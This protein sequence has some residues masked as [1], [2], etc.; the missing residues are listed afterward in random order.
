M[1]EEF[2][3]FLATCVG[4]HGS[5]NSDVLKSGSDTFLELQE[6]LKVHVPVD[7]ELHRVH[8]DARARATWIRLVSKTDSNALA[9]I[10]GAGT[11][12]ANFK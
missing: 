10:Y 5:P 4:L 12:T 9:V 3:D 6:A 8:L 1:I 2:L 7:V 11:V